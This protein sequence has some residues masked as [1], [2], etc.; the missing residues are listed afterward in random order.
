MPSYS[1]FQGV[2]IPESIQITTPI[3]QM[4]LG[5][6]DLSPNVVEHDHEACM[7][8][9]YSYFF[10]SYKNMIFTQPN[11]ISGVLRQV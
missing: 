11:K 10:L 6:L 4:R 8:G 1:Y 7:R 5:D 3:S 9:F 2:W